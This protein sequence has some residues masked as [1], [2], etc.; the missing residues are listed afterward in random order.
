MTFNV[1]LTEVEI[2]NVKRNYNLVIDED[3]N[4]LYFCSNDSSIR[5]LNLLSMKVEQIYIGHTEKINQMIILNDEFQ[6]FSCSNDKTLRRWC[7]GTQRCLQVIE[8]HEGPVNGMCFYQEKLYT[9]SFDATIKEYCLETN[10]LIHTFE[11]HLN[12]V[13]TIHLIQG[14]KIEIFS[15]SSDNTIIVWNLTTRSK[16]IQLKHHISWLTTK[17]LSE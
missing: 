9:C 1:K 3:E 7:L 16:V 11:G 10:S 13:H 14:E 17:L 12:N 5:Q 2:P 6:I 8:I 4:F 15:I